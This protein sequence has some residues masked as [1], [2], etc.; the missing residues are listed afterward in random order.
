MCPENQEIGNCAG[1]CQDS[2]ENPIFRSQCKAPCLIGCMCKEGYLRNSEDVCIKQEDC[3]CPAN[4]NYACTECQDTCEVRY[5]SQRCQPSE[6]CIPGC[7]C[8]EGYIRDEE[9][10][11][12]VLVGD[13][14]SK[15][16]D[17]PTSNLFPKNLYLGKDPCPLPNQRYSNC[18][19]KRSCQ[20][21]CDDPFELKPC[22]KNCV[23]GTKSS[24][25]K[26]IN[27]NF[28]KYFRVHL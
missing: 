18:N 14:P 21:T 6:D 4:E 8:D 5:I 20:N 7:I 26:K 3:P 24:F 9:S 16:I 2:C 25:S 11:N 23:S 1:A 22:T 19:G 13:C 28:V 10:G 17:F 27:V 12:C 15:L